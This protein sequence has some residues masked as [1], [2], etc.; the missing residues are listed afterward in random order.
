M[1]GPWYGHLVLLGKVE[2]ESLCSEASLVA[3]HRSGYWDLSGVA[4]AFLP[5][6][7]V[8]MDCS[9]SVRGLGLENEN[10]PRSQVYFS[11]EKKI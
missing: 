10:L 11:F 5:G 6:V 9:Y 1:Q 2:A 7:A 3:T 8:L 4:E